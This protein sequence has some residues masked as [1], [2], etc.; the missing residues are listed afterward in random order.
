MS[1]RPPTLYRIDWVKFEERWPKQFAEF[2]QTVA[3]IND[4]G[5][6]VVPV[7]PDGYYINAGGSQDPWPCARE[8]A[9]HVLVRLEDE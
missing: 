6:I 1:D 3:P 7:E 9:T 8:D 4:S 2:C 5:D